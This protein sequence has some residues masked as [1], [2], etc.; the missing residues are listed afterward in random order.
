MTTVAVLAAAQRIR[1]AIETLPANVLPITFSNFP[2]GACGDA[3][4]ILGTYLEEE[5]NLGAFDFV[6]AERGVC[7]DNTWTSH[8]WLQKGDLFVDITADQFLDAPSAIVVE[9]N[10]P[11]HDTFAV[12]RR[13]PS[14]LKSWTGHGTYQV[15]SLY[16]RI[17]RHLA[18]THS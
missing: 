13:N 10:S 18:G 15:L 16:A 4:L 9:V 8:A 14:N 3:C 2:R 17:K 12:E 5:C 1:T 6:T 11:W 7:A